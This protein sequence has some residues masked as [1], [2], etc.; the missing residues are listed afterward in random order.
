MSR[1][2]YHN[3]NVLTQ[4]KKLNSRAE[5]FL[6]EDGRF[7]AVGRNIDFN[8]SGI[9][10]INLQGKTVLPGFND[11]HIHLWK[12]GQL[13]DF[14]LDL[15]DAT[16]LED[17]G[18]A[19][20]KASAK[21]KPGEW[22]IGRGFNESKLIEGTIP[23]ASQLDTFAPEN[24]VYLLRTC[25]HI[26]VLNSLGMKRCGIDENT[27]APEGGTIGKS[28]ETVTGRLY[29]TALGLATKHLPSPSTSDYSDMILSGVK[30]LLPFG[31]TSITDPAVHP[32]L[33][34]A[35]FQLGDLPIRLNLI[36]ILLQ[37]GESEPLELPPCVEGDFLQIRW[38]KLFSDGG[39]SGQT[40]ALNRP[41]KNTSDQGI[42]RIKPDQF[43]ELASSAKQKG[44]N[45]ATHA[46]GDRA[47]AMVLQT[48]S[49]L[50]QRFGMSR[51]RIEHFG[52]PTDEALEQV[53]KTGTVVVPQ[54]IFLYELGDNF[55]SSL[56]DQYLQRCYPIQTLLN[57]NIPFALSTDAP[58]VKNI[59]PWKNIQTAITRKT[60]SEKVISPQEKIS[61]TD[62]LYA[63]TMG[64][65]YAE[66]KENS[67][68]SISA[69]KLA[70]FTIL[71]RDPFSVD[72]N[73]LE[74]IQA[75]AV[76]TGGNKV[77]EL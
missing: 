40:A 31:V 26:A 28:G 6:V 12:V 8:I 34:D 69:G 14:I 30:K 68:G 11:A 37:D 48:Y 55:I 51:N 27:V 56:D 43:L 67:K 60:Q 52:L 42:L 72:L 32:A 46:I 57:K 15:R 76:Y 47:I 36:P 77:F 23:Q 18:K 75:T 45:V 44:Y 71:D 65:A 22:I 62:A 70:D 2:L 74:S 61:L 13:G 39:S 24:P 53:I 41:Y 16:C 17:I 9:Q 33:S 49:N 1:V 50:N 19:I 64:S 3:G 21:K 20:S 10:K 59:N 7:I 38:T 66:E 29:E 4:D 54:P 58:V 73:E 63:M 35:Y 5:A 25:A